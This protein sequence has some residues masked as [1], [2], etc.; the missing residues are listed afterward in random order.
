M[1]KKVGN[2]F[3]S[4]YWYLNFFFHFHH[5]VFPALL[6]FRTSHY[7]LLIFHWTVH[8]S[9]ASCNRNRILKLSVPCLSYVITGYP[10]PSCKSVDCF[11][12]YESHSY[13]CLP[14]FTLLI[15]HTPHFSY[16]TEQ[17][18]AHP[19]PVIGT[20][21]RLLKLKNPCRARGVIIKSLLNTWKTVF[22]KMVVRKPLENSQWGSYWVCAM[23]IWLEIVPVEGKA[24]GG[25][26]A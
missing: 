26:G 23:W 14:L 25:G 24:S 13:S 9:S 3:Q 5:S 20:W 12:C 21:D 15:F 19:R 6:I 4:D 11:S 8:S 10:L 22:Y 1:W 17:Y 7:A 2:F 18:M 16:S